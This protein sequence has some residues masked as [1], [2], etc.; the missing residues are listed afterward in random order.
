MQSEQVIEWHF[1]DSG[2]GIQKKTK[3]VKGPMAF[4]QATTR[5]RVLHPGMRR[6]CYLSV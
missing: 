1:V 6:D 2:K 5:F 3:R 4:L